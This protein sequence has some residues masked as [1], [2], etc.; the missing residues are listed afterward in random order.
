MHRLH[1]D[2][3]VRRQR[4]LLLRSAELRVTLAYQAQALKSPLAFADQL[5]AGVR[6]LG[7]HPV[8]PMIALALLALWRPHPLL[9]WVPRLV[10]VSQLFLR[11]R[12]W[13]GKRAP[14]S[15]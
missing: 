5:R 4:Q 1:R 12:H 11:V 14:R 13:L 9:R 3:L 6:W 7:Q 8:W 10:G 15:P 2:E